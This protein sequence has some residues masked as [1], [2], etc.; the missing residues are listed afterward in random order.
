MKLPWWLVLSSAISV[1]TYSPVCAQEVSEI[2]KPEWSKCFIEAREYACLTLGQTKNY[3]LTYELYIKK[4]TALRLVEDAL[5]LQTQNFTA[6]QQRNS[7]L[8]V[9]LKVAQAQ[10][11]TLG[12]EN[13]AL[14]AEVKKV[15]EANK[16]TDVVAVC[17]TT[18]VL[19]LTLVVLSN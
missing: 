12:S 9:A 6:V 3:V 8:I 16:T 17:V 5:T 10:L 4:K 2:T 7:E 19:V 13:K 1:A 18:A 14:K 11:A 15:R